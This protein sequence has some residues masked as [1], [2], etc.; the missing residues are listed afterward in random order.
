MSAA[1]VLAVCMAWLQVHRA[2]FTDSEAQHEA[3]TRAHT[4]AALDTYYQN[5][6]ADER[7]IYDSLPPS[8]RDAF[9]VCRDLARCEAEPPPQFF[10]SGCQLAL[11]IGAL[12]TEAAR[13]LQRL[14]RI[15]IIA[16]TKQG[17]KRTAGVL[18]RANLWKWN[19]S[20]ESFE[21]RTGDDAE[22]NSASAVDALTDKKGNEASPP[23]R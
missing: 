22:S 4:K 23:E 8:E 20:L 11:R 6:E 19:M 7:G 17:T 2:W 15:G 18:G 1:R 12:P 16:M 3:E 21:R 5:I 14:K 9:R 10:L 13:T